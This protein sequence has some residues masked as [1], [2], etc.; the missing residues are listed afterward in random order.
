MGSLSFTD[1]GTRMNY[2]KLEKYFALGIK[3]LDCY[4]SHLLQKLLVQKPII[5]I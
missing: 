1:L 3:I 4:F 5:C 2:V